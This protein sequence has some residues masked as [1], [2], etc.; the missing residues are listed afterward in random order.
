M[1]NRFDMRLKKQTE[2]NVK[3]SVSNSNTLKSML[4]LSLDTNGSSLSDFMSKADVKVSLEFLSWA[5][6]RDYLGAE[7]IHLESR[8]DFKVLTDFETSVGSLDR[9]SFVK[10]LGRNKWKTLWQGQGYPVGFILDELTN[11]IYSRVYLC[12]DKK[13][14]CSRRKPAFRSGHSYASGY[15][16]MPKDL[17]SVDCKFV[18]GS[19]ASST[20]EA[21]GKVM[22]LEPLEQCFNKYVDELS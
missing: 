15:G 17:A 7:S 19:L 3:R 10:R 20:N 2:A 12:T 21:S 5:K 16:T 4:A 9:K 8:K 18:T 14:R 13:L 22:K 1:P 11:T 6:K